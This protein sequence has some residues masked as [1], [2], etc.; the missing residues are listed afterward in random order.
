METK[1]QQECKYCHGDKKVIMGDWADITIDGAKRTITA[2]C[3]EGD[4]LLEINYCPICG[5]KLKD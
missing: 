5:R 1:A 2:N 4:A 3:N